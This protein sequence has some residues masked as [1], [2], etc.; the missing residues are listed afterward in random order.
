MS[1]MAPTNFQL[2]SSD[3]GISLGFWC[4]PGEGLKMCHCQPLRESSRA[5][6]AQGDRCLG[7]GFTQYTLEG[8]PPATQSLGCAG[9]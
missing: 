1:Y 3:L 4:L 2:D 9:S 8:K 6:T 5:L 7:R